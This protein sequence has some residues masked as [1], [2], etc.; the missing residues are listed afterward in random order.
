MFSFRQRQQGGTTLTLKAEDGTAAGEWTP[1][2]D[3]TYLVVSDPA[4]TEG[5]YTL[6]CGETQLAGAAGMSGGKGGM[7]GGFRP[8][9]EGSSDGLKPPEGDPG[10]RPEKERPQPNEDG[11][12]TLPDGTVIDPAD[13]KRPEN[14][15]RPEPPDGFGGRP[16]DPETA[17][18]STDFMLTDKGGTF[19]SIA[20][21]E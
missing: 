10:Q 19:G 5:T 13:M 2:N 11:T 12:V 15:E 8:A 16:E 1:S 9:V 21:A 6:W 20:P 14:S 3:F 4:L 17:E 18:V 7:G